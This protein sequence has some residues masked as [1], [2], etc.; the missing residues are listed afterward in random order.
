[1][2]PPQAVRDAAYAQQQAEAEAASAFASTSA[3]D[4]SAAA[5]I[6]SASS[7][8]APLDYDA[9]A[10]R[11]GID[12]NVDAKKARSE[13]DPDEYLYTLQLM[14]EEHNF[15]GSTMEVRAKSLS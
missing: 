15:E 2:F 9:I 11:T 12:L 5:A 4:P 3:S 1:M 6:A 14:D 10:H 7:S 8:T 13:D